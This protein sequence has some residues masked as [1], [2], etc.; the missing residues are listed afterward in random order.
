MDSVPGPLPSH[1]PPARASGRLSR[2]ERLKVAALSSSYKA[3]LS[4]LP[5][6]VASHTSQSSG[7]GWFGFFCLFVL[8]FCFSPPRCENLVVEGRRQSGLEL[9]SILGEI[10]CTAG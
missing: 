4:A 2:F 9:Q 10:V 8:S 1:P 3:S 5:G 7:Q 6:A